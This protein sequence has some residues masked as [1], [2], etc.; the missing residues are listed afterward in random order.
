MSRISEGP[1]HERLAGDA[2]ANKKEAVRREA[3]RIAAEIDGS[4][5]KPLVPGKS[6]KMVAKR[7]GL[8][9]TVNSINNHS[10]LQQN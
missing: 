4:T 9:S 7:R 3:E 6:E 2:I 8:A 1:V 10:K 5:F